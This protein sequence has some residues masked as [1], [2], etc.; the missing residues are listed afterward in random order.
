MKKYREARKAYTMAALAV[1]ALVFAAGC[2]SRVDVRGPRIDLPTAPSIPS[3]PSGATVSET[4]AIF[5]VDGVTLAAVGHVRIAVDG[6][7]S[8][9]I[10][11]PESVMGLLTS[12]VVGGR[13]LLDRDSASYQGQASDIQYDISLR[14]LEE[15]ELAGVGRISAR[16]IDTALFSASV[17][18]VGEIEAAGRAERQEVT[19]AGVGAYYAPMLESRVAHVNI[20]AGDAMVWATERLE[21]WVG[22][23][24]ELEYWGDPEVLVQ[25]GGTVRALGLKN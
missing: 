17:N 6:S 3:V 12:E 11:A 21:G 19:V 24:C 23:G 18:G 10:S 2:D 16:G 7:E 20:S 9:T 1:A 8:L 14:R 22:A 4:R 5:G 13:L 15:L 25:G